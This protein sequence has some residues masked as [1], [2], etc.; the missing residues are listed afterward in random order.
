MSYIR[1]LIWGK[2]IT[3]LRGWELAHTFSFLVKRFTERSPNSRGGHNWGLKL[4]KS[5][6]WVIIVNYYW[7]NWIIIS[8]LAFILLQITIGYHLSRVAYKDFLMLET[9]FK[10][11]LF[12][13][14][15]IYWGKMPTFLLTLLKSKYTAIA[16]E[17]Q[18]YRCCLHNFFDCP[19]I[20]I[21]MKNDKVS[22]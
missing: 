1:S 12:C 7:D 3:Q 5:V 4:L 6:N 13:S 16:L 21:F 10:K 15:T 2:V 20:L 9:H 14:P 17:K 11:L 8:F 22:Y 18:N 19:A